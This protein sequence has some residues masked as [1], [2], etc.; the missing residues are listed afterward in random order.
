M[1]QA[2]KSRRQW[3]DE[4]KAKARVLD[5]IKKWLDKIAKTETD[6]GTQKSAHQAMRFLELAQ[7]EMWNMQYWGNSRQVTLHEHAE[8]E[9]I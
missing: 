6:W 9:T 1:P 2:R 3:N 7:Y 8:K 4:V 5:P